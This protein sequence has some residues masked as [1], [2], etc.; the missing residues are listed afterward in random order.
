MGGKW[1][2]KCEHLAQLSNI[3]L[4]ET[5]SDSH[6]P[7]FSLPFRMAPMLPL[8]QWL[9]RS[10]T[11][12]MLGGYGYHDNWAFLVF[13]F[14]VCGCLQEFGQDFQH[15]PPPREDRRCV[16]HGRSGVCTCVCVHACKHV[17]VRVWCVCERELDSVFMCSLRYI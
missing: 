2:W 5:L 14:S 3:A 9:S 6:T 17:C 16:L 15:C 4:I 12:T 11:M 13:V 8:C 7:P 10:V 1:E